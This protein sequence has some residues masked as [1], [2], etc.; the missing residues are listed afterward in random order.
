[1]YLH[2]TEEDKSIFFVRT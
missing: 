2:Q 1:M